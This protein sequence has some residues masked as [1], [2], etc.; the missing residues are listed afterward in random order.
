MMEEMESEYR[1][2]RQLLGKEGVVI[3]YMPNKFS[4][5]RLLPW[6]QAK[7]TDTNIWEVIEKCKQPRELPR[8]EKHLPE[9]D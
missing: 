2:M 9:A 5:E 1:D 6:S 8:H 4:P 3:A 7:C